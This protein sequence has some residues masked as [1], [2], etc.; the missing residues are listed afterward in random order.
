M[1]RGVTPFN[2]EKVASY[3]TSEPA[4]NGTVRRYS[5]DRGDFAYIRFDKTLAEYKPEKYFKGRRLLLRELISRQFRLQAVK[6][7]D[8]FVTNK[9]MQSILQLS[10]SPDLKLF[11]GAVE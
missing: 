9:S 8:D 10:N 1:Q 6:A 7:E 5:L 3:T 2:L 11:V 4:F